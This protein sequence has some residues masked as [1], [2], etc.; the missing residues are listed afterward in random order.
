[1]YLE[2]CLAVAEATR[3]LQESIDLDGR[4][5]DFDVII[6][7][8]DHLDHPNRTI[9]VRV[10]KVPRFKSCQVDELSDVGNWGSCKMEQR[11]TQ[12]VNRHGDPVCRIEKPGED[13]KSLPQWTSE[14]PWAGRTI[15]VFITEPVEPARLRRLRFGGSIGVLLRKLGLESGNDLRQQERREIVRAESAQN[16]DDLNDPQSK[17]HDIVFRQNFVS[18]CPHWSWLPE[19]VTLC[20]FVSRQEATDLESTLLHAMV[21]PLTRLKLKTGDVIVSESLENL[22]KLTVETRTSMTPRRTRPRL[23]EQ[24]EI[25][26]LGN[27]G[28]QLS[29]LR[30]FVKAHFNEDPPSEDVLK[31][32]G[33]G[34]LVYGA[35]DQSTESWICGGTGCGKTRRRPLA[36]LMA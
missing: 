17:L 33:Y 36:A 16:N 3:E 4:D 32:L 1:M 30:E 23:K 8:P 9:V 22:I 27:M 24:G 18:F 13:G 15:F 31:G 14:A 25:P 21:D 2:Q 28:Y 6:P 7:E 11:I 26:R 19:R 5:R 34:L 10:H 29:N 35:V 20:V 12:M